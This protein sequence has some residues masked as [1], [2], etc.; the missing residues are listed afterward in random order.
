MFSM[1]A[2][3][4]SSVYS[5]MTKGTLYSSLF[6]GFLNSS[7][8]TSSS[9]SS[10]VFLPAVVAWS[11]SSC[12]SCGVIAA[13]SLLSLS[14]SACIVGTVGEGALLI[15]PSSAGTALVTVALVPSAPAVMF[16][17]LTIVGANVCCLWLSDVV[18]AGGC[19]GSDGCGGGGCNC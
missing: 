19:G 1:S 9:S 16:P 13:A 7:G 11:A 2:L 6:S 4:D 12:S 10:S 14:F 18:A 8:S 5:C 15:S 17:V 3:S